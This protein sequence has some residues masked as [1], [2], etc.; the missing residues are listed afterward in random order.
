MTIAAAEDWL[1]AVCK[2]ALGSQVTVT[3]GPHD[4]DGSFAKK[5]LT[6]L[7]GVV[8]VFNGGTAD[9]STSLTLNATWTLHVVTGWQ[10]GD[11]ASRRRAATTGAYAILT[12]LGVRLHNTNM[13]ARQ[14]TE[15]GG[16]GPVPNIPDLDSLDGFGAV[17]VVGMTNESGGE[18]EAM[19]LTVWVLEIDQQM[20]LEVPVDAKLQ[21]WLRAHVDFDL[22]DVGEDVDLES[23]FDLEQ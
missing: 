4:W 3:T 12:V 19:G 14:F 18:W 16:G 2:D 20:P 17:S 10:G 22:P 1:V 11:Q 6:A 21:D 13:G 9:K 15:S 5:F 7:P 23:D 8:V